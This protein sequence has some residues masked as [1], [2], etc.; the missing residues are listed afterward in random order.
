MAVDIDSQAF[1]LRGDLLALL[2]SAAAEKLP[3]V[4]PDKVLSTRALMH[5]MPETF[6]TVRRSMSA[7]A[8]RQLLG[9][10]RHDCMQQR[11]L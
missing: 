7:H 1:Y 2:Q 11:R 3:P 4:A 8:E 9:L 6:V 10:S 5:L